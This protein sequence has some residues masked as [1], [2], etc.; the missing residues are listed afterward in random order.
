M[1]PTWRWFGPQ[2]IVSIEW[3]QQAGARGVVSALH[4]LNA[5]EVWSKEEI[6]KRKSEITTNASGLQSSL[7]WDVVESLPV[8]EE[9]KTQSGFWRAHIDNWCTSLEALAASGIRTVCYNFMPVLDWTRTDFAFRLSHGGTAMRFDAIDF[10]VFD[11]FILERFGASEEWSEDVLA[12]ASCRLADMTNWEKEALV[13]RLVVGLPGTA[14]GMTRDKFK[15]IL[16]TYS[17]VTPECLRRNFVTF[18]QEVVPVAERLG[19]RLCCH[20]DDPP[21]PLL[22]L[23]RIMSTEQ[24]YLAMLDSVDSS[25]NGVTLCSG[26]FG[27]RADNDIPGMMNRLGSRVHFLHLRNVTRENDVL[28]S[29]F[30]EAEHLGGDTDMPALVEAILAEEKRRKREGRS[31]W[32]IPFRPDHG[33]NIMSD[34]ASKSLPGYPAVGRM[35]GLAELRGL[36][37]GLKHK[38]PPQ[39]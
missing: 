4:H 20:P 1:K 31:D 12:E 26:S 5:G 24:D 8:S 10:A 35:R 30:F 14:V 11:I 29:S 7:T 32:D 6:D 28:G 22:G 16:E 39:H 34:L 17:D 13:E 38:S 2:D 23:P 15:T 18:L 21:F 9:I 25:A 37:A 19:M 27:A 36:I 3:M 33:Q